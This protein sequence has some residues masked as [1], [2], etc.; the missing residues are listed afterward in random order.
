VVHEDDLDQASM[1]Q[2]VIR[3]V[4][5]PLVFCGGAAVIWLSPLWVLAVVGYVGADFAV[6]LASASVQTL[7]DKV[8]RTV[9]VLVN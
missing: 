5:G 9:V 1:I 4:C 2:A 3:F 8:A 6:G 7:H